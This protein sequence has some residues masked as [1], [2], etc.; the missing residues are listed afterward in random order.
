MKRLIDNNGYSLV[1]LLVAVLLT[2]ILSMAGLKFY[3]RIHNQTLTQEDI[4]DMQAAARN[5]L[6]EIS[7]TLRN[8]GYKVGSHPAYYISSDTLMVFYSDSQLVDTIS[9]Y[10]ARPQELDHQEGHR[11]YSL[12]KKVNS[13]VAAEYADY[14]SGITYTLISP[15]VIDVVVSVETDRSDEDYVTNDGVRAFSLS[16]RVQIR[17]LKL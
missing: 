13:N 15:S 10:L 5:S 14:I 3:A 11:T 7:G 12:M 1:E 16:E 8:A 9:Y 6:D 17:N 4:G 2:G